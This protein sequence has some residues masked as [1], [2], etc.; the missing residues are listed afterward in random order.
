MSTR[1][2]RAKHD[3]D[4]PRCFLRYKHPCWIF[5][6]RFGQLI[7]IG[8]VALA[9]PG[10]RSTCTRESVWSFLVQTRKLPLQHMTP[11]LR[12]SC[13]TIFGV[14]SYHLQ[15]GGFPPQDFGSKRPTGQWYV[16]FDGLAFL[17]QRAG[18]TKAFRLMAW[19]RRPAA[20]LATSVC[21]RAMGHKTAKLG[22]DFGL[23]QPDG[24]TPQRLGIRNRCGSSA[25]SERLSSL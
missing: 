5:G 2:K 9:N 24:G 6:L 3:R 18:N 15:S 25:G 1:S 13:P 22:A 12:C 4:S 20:I 14:S 10:S 21:A 8:L 11:G 16:W 23:A 17:V 7:C 19:I